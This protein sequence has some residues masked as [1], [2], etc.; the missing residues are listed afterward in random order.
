[1]IGISLCANFFS[2]SKYIPLNEILLQKSD[3]FVIRVT[4]SFGV[5]QL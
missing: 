3:G 4:V 2:F 5:Q 1:M